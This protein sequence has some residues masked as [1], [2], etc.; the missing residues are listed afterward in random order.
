M[1]QSTL[2][3]EDD[4]V[5][6]PNALV[7]TD[8]NAG[9]LAVYP[10]NKEDIDAISVLLTRAFAGTPEEIRQ[11]DCRSFTEKVVSNPDK[12]CVLAARLIPRDKS[13]LPPGKTSRLVGTATLSF[14]PDTR[15]AFP[16]LQPSPSACYMANMAVDP[17]FRR[18]GIARALLSACEAVSLSKGLAVL[19][20]HV[21]QGDDPAVSLYRGWGC[22]ETLRD[23]IMVRMLGYRPRLLLRKQLQ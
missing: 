3:Q 13:L 16:T 10:S 15:E 20:L 6:C 22:E 4:A 19:E 8:L 11:Q 5:E 17:R 12:G 9:L 21:R 1:P 18:Q 2:R 23:S 7:E 14:H